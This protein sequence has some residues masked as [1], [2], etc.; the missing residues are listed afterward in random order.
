MRNVNFKHSPIYRSNLTG[1]HFTADVE[2]AEPGRRTERRSAVFHY[3]VDPDQS[4]PLNFK[5]AFYFEGKG[6]SSTRSLTFSTVGK[7]SVSVRGEACIDEVVALIVNAAAH[8]QGID[9][10]EYAAT[11]LDRGRA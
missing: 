11:V 2:I 7:D 10:R 4:Y 3:G 9:P 8:A 6:N 1:Q 5:D